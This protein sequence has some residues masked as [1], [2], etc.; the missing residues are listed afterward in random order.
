MTNEE[1]TILLKDLCAR[2]FYGVMC[3]RLGQAKK[4]LSVSPDKVYCIELDNGEYTPSKYKVED[5]KPY[6]RP[7]SSMTVEEDCEFC[8][9]FKCDSV[10]A[11]YGYINWVVGG[12]CDYDDFDIEFSKLAKIIDWLNAHHFDYRGLIEKGLAIEAPEDMYKNI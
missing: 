12:S 4:L 3:D 2:S 5:V 8:R 1:K 6:L 11:M 9:L 10:N 7:I